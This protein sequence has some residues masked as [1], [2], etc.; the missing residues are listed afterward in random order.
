M[1][2]FCFQMNNCNLCQNS[3]SFVVAEALKTKLLDQPIHHKNF[4]DSLKNKRWKK[5][6]K[7]QIFQ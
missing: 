2:E 3:I 4:I 1:V 6:V 7:L 5:R